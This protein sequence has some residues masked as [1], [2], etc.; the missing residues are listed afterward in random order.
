MIDHGTGRIDLAVPPR[1]CVKNDA[2]PA[3]HEVRKV[4]QVLSDPTAAA[5][6][7]VRVIDE[8]GEVYR[9]RAL[10]RESHATSVAVDEA[11]SCGFSHLS[12]SDRVENQQHPVHANPFLLLYRWRRK[13]SLASRRPGPANRPGALRG[14]RSLETWCRRLRGGGPLGKHQPHKRSLKYPGTSQV[15]P[16]TPGK[17]LQG[18]RMGPM[19]RTR[20]C[21]RHPALPPGPVGSIPSGR[22][23]TPLQWQW[24]VTSTRRIILSRSSCRRPWPARSQGHHD[25]FYESADVKPQQSDSCFSLCPPQ[26]KPILFLASVPPAAVVDPHD[27]RPRTAG[28]LGHVE[29]ELLGYSMS[30]EGWVPRSTLVRLD[31]SWQTRS[32]DGRGTIPAGDD[33]RRRG[34][35]IAS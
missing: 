29:V 24:S 2:Y 8:S 22:E 12:L 20:C 4:Y 31:R 3:S 34:E 5:R 21:R 17:S 10:A 26:P 35:S 18:A 25:A 27:Q 7:F 32:R 19:G 16:G 28:P 6:G 9:V 11:Y 30:S 13:V 1:C 15:V 33:R 14:T 23:A